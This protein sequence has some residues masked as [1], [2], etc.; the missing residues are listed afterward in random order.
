MSKTDSF[1]IFAVEDDDWYREFIGYILS[2]N[3]DFEVKKFATGKELLKHLHE[4][5]HVVTIDYRLPDTDGAS[6]IRQI[7]EFNPD[8]EMVVISEQDKVDTAVELL[9]LGVY[10]YIVKSKDIKEKLLNVISNIRKN[11]HLKSRLNTLEQ[12]VTQKYSFQNVIIG[13]SEP[14]QRVFGLLEKAINTNISV[15]ITGETGTGKELVAKA[16]HYNS[17]RK[18]N[19]F[20]AVNVS[21][22][23]RDL[24]ESELFG[25]EKG[26]FTGASAERIG[27]FETA[28]K[29]TIFLDEIGEM[30]LNLQAKLLRVLQE[31]ELTR[32]GG[33][34]VIS[35]DCRVIAATNKNLLEEVKKGNFREDLYYR[36]YGLPIELP[37]LRE[38]GND[39]IILA[40]HFID[41][42]CRENNLG[43]K[44]LTPDAQEKLFSHPFPGNI[45]ELKSVVELAAVMADNN[46]ITAKDI[47]LHKNS[48]LSEMLDEEKTMD[49]YIRQILKFYLKKHNDNVMLV[50]RKLNMGKSTIY[51]ILKENP[52]YFQSGN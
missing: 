40:K 20:V 11:Q 41:N 37:P 1:R 6:L 48:N 36:L 28:D 21:A 9:K 22:I 44:S 10:D 27:K 45:R 4:N 38:R 17:K 15:L 23:P 32:V 42:F 7:R 19:A 16:I 30:D 3:P 12:E 49:N 50:A 52:E 47:V 35:I 2:L 34:K 51:R 33:N 24:A 13:Q 43:K 29:G 14:I 46:S 8:I 25:H 39:L 18:K 31:K 5:P 26:S